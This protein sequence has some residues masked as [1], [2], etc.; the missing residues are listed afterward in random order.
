MIRKLI[1]MTRTMINLMM[2]TPPPTRM[3]RESGRIAKRWQ[4]GKQRPKYD[5]TRHTGFAHWS[6]LMMMMMVVVIVVMMI[7]E[8]SRCQIG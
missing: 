7:R 5:W 6:I 1:V 4:Q 3:T 8:G 2:M